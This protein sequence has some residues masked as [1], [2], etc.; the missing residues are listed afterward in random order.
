MI[1]VDTDLRN[2][3][4]TRREGEIGLRGRVRVGEGRSLPLSFIIYWSSESEIN[5]LL[6]T[7]WRALTK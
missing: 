6:V 4:D 3:L 5:T 1:C 7:K 2:F